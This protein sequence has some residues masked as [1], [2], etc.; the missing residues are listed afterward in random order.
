MGREGD[1]L[2]EK[3]LRRTQM[4]PFRKIRYSNYSTFGKDSKLVR[5]CHTMSV[6]HFFV[7][8]PYFAKDM[9]EFIWYVNK[10]YFVILSDASFNNKVFFRHVKFRL[11]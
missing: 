10:P 3:L 2:F 4:P 8:L 5:V 6:C 9:L 7:V 11:P 1:C